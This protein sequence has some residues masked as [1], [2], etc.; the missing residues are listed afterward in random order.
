MDLTA[1]QSYRD[2]RMP[3]R[4]TAIVT[5]LLLTIMPLLTGCGGGEETG[6]QT[7]GIA[8]ATASLE[9]SPISDHS[10]YAYFVHYGQ[11]SPGH[12]GSCNYESSIW[13]D[14]PSATITDLDP[15]TLYYFAV[16]A[17]LMVEKAPAQM[18]YR[19]SRLQHASSLCLDRSTKSPP[20]PPMLNTTHVIGRAWIAPDDVTEQCSG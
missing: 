8:G 20:M 7:I 2:A 18:K 4:L 11:K 17:Y 15:N 5:G 9:W 3:L 10:V 19:S 12:H 6:S 1:D 16:S 14:S 13:V